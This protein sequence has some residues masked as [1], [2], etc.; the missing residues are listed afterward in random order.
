VFTIPTTVQVQEHAS[1]DL[2]E[3]AE[4]V[5]VDVEMEVDPD[6]DPVVDPVVPVQRH[7]ELFRPILQ[8]M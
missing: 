3:V 5:E 1:L 4:G 6:P 2:E 8:V 7:L